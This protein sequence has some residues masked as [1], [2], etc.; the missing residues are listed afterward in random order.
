MTLKAI[1]SSVN[2][3]GSASARPGDTVGTCSLERD[4]IESSVVAGKNDARGIRRPVE[5]GEYI[6]WFVGRVKV[7]VYAIGRV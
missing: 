5:T 6:A 1:S 3:S 4:D 2:A 7:I